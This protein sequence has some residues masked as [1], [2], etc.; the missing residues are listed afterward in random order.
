M[1]LPML[2]RTTNGIIIQLMLKRKIKTSKDSLNY[3]KRRMTEARRS[4]HLVREGLLTPKAS[5]TGCGA[6][7]G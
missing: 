2:T 6:G 1:T 7:M 5:L 4:C 3:L